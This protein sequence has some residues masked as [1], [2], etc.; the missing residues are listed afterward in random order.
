[1]HPGLVDSNLGA[2][3]Q[4]PKVVKVV[5]GWYDA[6]WGRVDGDKGSWTSVFCAASPDMKSEQSGTYFQ[7]IAEAGWESG[8][9]KDTAPAAKL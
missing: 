7:R 4:I 9:V 8:M 1:M 2:N 5:V 6:I 3:A